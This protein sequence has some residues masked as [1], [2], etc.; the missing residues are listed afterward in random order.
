[1]GL[2]FSELAGWRSR[3]LCKF[4]QVQRSSFA[5]KPGKVSHRVVEGDREAL[6]Q[7]LIRIG[8]QPLAGILDQV[9]VYPR[10]AGE[11]VGRQ[12]SSQRAGNLVGWQQ[13]R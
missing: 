4:P 6:G 11:I 8:T 12:D 9:E 3:T 5:K 1:M 10:V 7:C 13:A 2:G